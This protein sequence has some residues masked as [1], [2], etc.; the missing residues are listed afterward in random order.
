M[1]YAVVHLLLL[2]TTPARAVQRSTLKTLKEF[3]DSNTAILD[4]SKQ[5]NAD[6]HVLSA[7]YNLNEVPTNPY[8][9]NPDLAAEFAA[10]DQE[11]KDG[12]LSAKLAKDEELSAG[13]GSSQAANLANAE[14]FFADEGSSQERRVVRQ[15]H[16]LHIILD[17]WGWG[18]ATWHRPEKILHHMPKTPSIDAL[19]RQGVEL[20]RHY[21]FRV[22]SPTRSAIQAGRNPLQVNI[23]NFVSDHAWNSKDNV[24]GFAGIPMAMT[25]VAEHL[26]RAGYDTHF[27]G[28]W[29][30]GMA[31]WRH[32]PSGRGYNHSLVYWGHGN[33]MWNF[34]NGVLCG[35]DPHQ[36]KVNIKELWEDDGP[37]WNLENDARCGQHKQR[38][39]QGKPCVYEEVLFKNRVVKAIKERPANKPLFIVWAPH[40]VHLPYQIPW[41]W[42]QK[43]SHIQGDWQRQYLY[44]LLEYADHEIGTV[45]RVLHDTGIW[46]DT[47]VVLHSDNGAAVEAAGNN[48]PLKG[49]KNSNWEGGI[50]VNALVSG[51]FLPNNARGTKTEGLI[52]GWDWYATFAKLAGEDPTDHAARMAGLP[53]IDSYDMWP[54]IIGQSKES[55]R[56]Q[57][58]IGDTDDKGDSEDGAL[59]QAWVGGL[60]RGQYKLVV[61]KLHQASWTTMWGANITDREDHKKKIKKRHC[62]WEPEIGCL[63]NIFDDPQE[64]ENIAMN[65]T[66]VFRDMLKH[67]AAEHHKVF[68]PYRGK[69]RKDMAC[70]VA[71]NSYKGY[72][73][74]FLSHPSYG[75]KPPL[76]VSEAAADVTKRMR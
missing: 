62:G 24:S 70:A 54:M 64:R 51:G 65:Y 6:T 16:I 40:L 9:S 7:N 23:Q 52:T 50:R 25:G 35:Q 42:L 66:D 28:K 60:I 34:E 58:L 76:L 47:L 11:W 8:A 29:D 61:G 12:T 75:R 37:A 53:P 10:E 26:T 32:T 27:Y 49:G 46:K 18:D 1:F 31:T 57:I 68:N 2:L 44:A 63:Y 39:G 55:P 5:Y 45:V 38:P 48:W 22:C 72:W 71:I 30:A 17:D 3:D 20:D 74:P 59:A 67:M 13:E 43:W 19:L 41:K 33:D 4:D 73:G 21:V 14:E 69:S 56:N 36:E 15:P